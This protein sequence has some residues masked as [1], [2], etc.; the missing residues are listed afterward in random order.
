M[1]VATASAA[2]TSTL[3]GDQPG[4]ALCQNWGSSM[5][6]SGGL[7]EPLATWNAV[8]PGLPSKYGTVAEITINFP[9]VLC[10]KQVQLQLATRSHTTA[11][12]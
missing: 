10:G 6:A 9:Y 5:Y 11:E 1:C 2:N 12:V 7:L 4:I 8:Y 3:R